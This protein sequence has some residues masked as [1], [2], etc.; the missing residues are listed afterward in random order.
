MR[1]AAA[2]G[3]AVVPRGAGT[4]LS[5][6]AAAIDGGIVLSTE[7]MTRILEIDPANL[8]ARVE[9]GRAQRGAE[10]GRRRARALV[11]ARSG[12]PG[13]L[14]HRRQHRHQ[15]RRPVLRQVRRHPR[16]RAGGDRRAGRR[17]A[18][19]ARRAAPSSGS[20]GSTC[21]RCWWGPRARSAVVA[22]ATLRLRPLPAVPL[23]LAANFPTLVAAG[24]AVEAMSR[25]GI[26]PR[27]WS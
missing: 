23:T 24:E 19:R 3:V 25:A 4:G 12:Q 27:C 15:R 7:L 13:L 6:G 11:R 20:R 5:G 22:E 16:E 2:H 17:R 9:A 8:V 18:R 1:V 26:T 10:G 21:C 14:H